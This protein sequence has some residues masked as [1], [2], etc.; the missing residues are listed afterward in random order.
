MSKLAIFGGERTRKD[1]FPAYKYI[2][3]SEIEAV[4]ETMRTG[5]LSKFI[6]GWHPDFNGG[7]AVRA[8]ELAWSQR[9]QS[10]HA[11]AMNSATSGLIAALGAIGI[12]PGDEVIVGPYSM[13][14][15][16]TAPLF[17]GAIPVF[18]DIDAHTYN[19]DPE[20]I[21]KCITAKT[22]AIIVVDLFGQIYDHEP[23][24]AIA[25]EYGIPVIE[26]ASQAPGAMWHDKMAGTL[27]DIGVFSLNY[28]KHIHSGEGGVVVTDNAEYAMRMR[29]IRNHAE[30]VVEGMG[31]ENLVNMI[32]FNFRMTEIEATIARVQ[33]EKMDDLIEQRIKN[34]QYIEE[35]LKHIPYL[36]MP[37]VQPGM[38][39]V[40]YKHA[41]RFDETLAGLSRNR[42]FE[43]VKAELM[44][45]AL[46]ESEGINVS[47]GYVKPIYLLPLFQKQIAM[48]HEGFP[49]K[50]PYVDKV[51]DYS[52]GLCPV[53]ED[54]HFK[55]LVSHEY[56]RPPMSQRDLDDFVEAIL[57]VHKYREEL[58]A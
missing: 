48:G 2:D 1:L 41:M 37:Y 16:A 10:E 55:T 50:S 54:L 29:L 4:V 36:S 44:P 33:L 28:H 14:I 15:S 11:I 58:N 39:H 46:R 31:Y 30:A 42:F 43:A 18:A 56:M 20:S 21:R 22:K 6:G 8:L 47:L 35:K 51:F 23:I 49:F 9:Y 3:E 26:D 5:V 38:K 7:E 24:N 53:C 52:K 27:G 32:G 12:S 57:K 45:I 40:Y 25:K 13:T 19:M 17:Y 34:V